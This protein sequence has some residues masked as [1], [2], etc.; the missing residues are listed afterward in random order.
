MA[1]MTYGDFRAMVEDTPVSTRM[2]EFRDT[3]GALVA[4]CLADRM[5]DGYSAVYSFYDPNR[6]GR[7]LGTF[8]ILSSSWRNR[9]GCPGSIWGTGSPTA[10]RWP[11]RRAS[12]RW[13]RSARKVGRRSSRRRSP[14]CIRPSRSFSSPS[15]QVPD[16]GS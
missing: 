13:R 5:D 16:T 10:A 9:K 2:L 15:R 1:D 8:A 4:G 14:K 7:S 3:I 6:D 12:S 11:T